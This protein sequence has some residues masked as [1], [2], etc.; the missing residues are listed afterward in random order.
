MIAAPLVA[1]G[2]VLGAISFLRTTTQ[3]GYDLAEQAIGEELARR[4]ATA[5]ENAQLYRAAVAA[6]EAKSSLPRGDVAMSCER[7]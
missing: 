5:I 1:R 3:P 2:R 6:S 4:T 7:R